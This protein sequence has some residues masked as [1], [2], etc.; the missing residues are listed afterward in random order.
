MLCLDWNDEKPFRIGGRENDIEY[1][2]LDIVLTPCNYLHT[3]LEYKDDTI[4]PECIPDL[5]S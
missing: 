2:R 3:M 5:E 4:S 1:A